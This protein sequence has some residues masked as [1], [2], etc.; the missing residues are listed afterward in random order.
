MKLKVKHVK[1]KRKDHSCYKK[2]IIITSIVRVYLKI[3]LWK[4][5]IWRW[6]F[7][8][9]ATILRSMWYC[10]LSQ[11]ITW[12]IYAGFLSE[13]YEL[14]EGSSFYMHIYVLIAAVF[15][16]W[17]KFYLKFAYFQVSGKTCLC[18]QN[19]LEL[20]IYYPFIENITYHDNHPCD[21]SAF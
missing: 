4:L 5:L 1:L 8:K 13:I 7:S 11:G 17:R 20:Y 21:F 15:M 10:C 19:H 12:L 2:W 14:K 18:D 16:T 6:H 9:G 3:N